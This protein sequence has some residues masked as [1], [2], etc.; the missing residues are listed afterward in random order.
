MFWIRLG[1]FFMFLGVLL[2][3]FGAHGLKDA[4]SL[5]GKQIYQTAVLYHLI[6]ALGLLAVGWLALLKPG[7][8]LV[9]SAGW[10]FVIG[11]LLF[12]GSLYLLSLT[13]MRKLGMITPLGGLAFLTGWLSLA[14]AA[15]G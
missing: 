8:A 10:S 3:A 6:H 7:E 14:F 11:I 2:G 15:K 4:L 9:R 5:E 1:G 13:G 12:S